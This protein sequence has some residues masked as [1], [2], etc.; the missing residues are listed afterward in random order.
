MALADLARAVIDRGATK[1]DAKYSDT[2]AMAVSHDMELPRE[3]LRRR[4]NVIAP[5]GPQGEHGTKE[6][7]EWLTKAHRR[8][9][10]SQTPPMM[11][12]KRMS[13]LE[14]MGR[15]EASR[16]AMLSDEQLIMR[17]SK[18]PAFEEAGP[19]PFEIRERMDWIR[20]HWKSE[21]AR[22]AE[23]GLEARDQIF[24]LTGNSYEEK[25]LSNQLDSA[26]SGWMEI[27]SAGLEKRFGKK[28]SDD[29]EMR[30]DAIVEEL[31]NERNRGR[32]DDFRPTFERPREMELGL[33]QDVH[34]TMARSALTR[35]RRTRDTTESSNRQM[36]ATK[37]TPIVYAGR[38]AVNIEGHRTDGDEKK[39]EAMKAIV[40]LPE[41]SS[42]R[43]ATGFASNARKVGFVD[44][45]GREL[46]AEVKLTNG[47]M[48]KFTEF[49][50]DFG[51]AGDFQIGMSLQ[52][53][54]AEDARRA[55]RKAQTIFA[56]AGKTK[57]PLVSAKAEPNQQASLGKFSKRITPLPDN[58]TRENAS[59]LDKN[60]E[61]LKSFHDLKNG[62]GR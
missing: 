31:R 4:F 58:L 50:A 10:A 2:I 12:G 54:V 33:T 53:R 52:D 62:K 55:K 23:L 11:A 22:D 57:M 42:Q 46:S 38:W 24:S 36:F 39:G 30:R 16:T 6:R 45:V 59:K 7:R 21:R 13:N 37:V 26:A 28:F 41:G 9:I 1:V 19:P 48:K 51:K 17:Y 20:N 18:A 56:A 15:D 5:E 44:L 8:A 61:L 34:S 14:L 60:F 32:M 35:E 3:V 43:A 47:T 49:Q 29:P 25:Q 27:S 40:V